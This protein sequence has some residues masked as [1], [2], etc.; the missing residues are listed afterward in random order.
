MRGY[1]SGANISSGAINSGKDEKSPISIPAIQTGTADILSPDINRGATSGNNC[2]DCHKPGGAA[3]DAA[4]ASC[5]SCHV[6]HDRS[7]E[8]TPD[9][10]LVAKSTDV[11]GAEPATSQ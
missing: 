5:V 8:R 4:T 2:V 11:K 3:R 7:K 6:F 9:G 10:K 1:P